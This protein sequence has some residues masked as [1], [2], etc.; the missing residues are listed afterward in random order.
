M[1]CD[2]RDCLIGLAAM[3]VFPGLVCGA[4]WVIAHIPILREVI[5]GIIMVFASILGIVSMGTIS[6]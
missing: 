3:V 6:Q 5:F 2:W 1:N 4:V